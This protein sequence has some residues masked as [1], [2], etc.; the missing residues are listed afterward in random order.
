MQNIMDVKRN[1]M[2]EE[3]L[4]LSPMQ[5]MEKMSQVFNDMIALK[6]KT[7]GVPEY[8]VY[9]SFL[10]AR[11]RQRK[12]ERKQKEHTRQWAKLVKRDKNLSTVLKPSKPDELELDAAAVLINSQ[13]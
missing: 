10:D 1:E 13:K 4:K 5:R 6:A 3:F 9:L 7:L 8:E 11:D 12:L 2:R